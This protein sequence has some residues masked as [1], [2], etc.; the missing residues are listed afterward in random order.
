MIERF[1][2]LSHDLVGSYQHT[3]SIVIQRIDKF[4]FRLTMSQPDAQANGD[5]HGKDKYASHQ[6]DQMS[7]FHAVVSFLVYPFLSTEF[8]A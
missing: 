8:P 5:Q 1:L 2:R 3:R 7:G 6:T 4:I